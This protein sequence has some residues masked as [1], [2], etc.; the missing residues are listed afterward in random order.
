M[1][2][3]RKKDKSGLWRVELVNVN[4][5]MT[6]LPGVGQPALIYGHARN[7]RDFL[8]QN[9]GGALYSAVSVKLVRD[10]G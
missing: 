4:G 1:S 2:W 10:V 3:F 5:I 8:L 9:R 7:L 6:Y